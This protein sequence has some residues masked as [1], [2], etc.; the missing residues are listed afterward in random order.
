M[1]KEKI[2]KFREKVQGVKN[3]F[4]LLFGKERD[5]A[6]V[7]INSLYDFVMTELIINVFPIANMFKTIDFGD[8]GY[9][10]ILY[11]VGTHEVARLH[12][13]KG[14][15]CFLT[16]A[17]WDKRFDLNPIKKR[18]TLPMAKDIEEAK[19]FAVTELISIMEL[20]KAAEDCGRVINNV[21]KEN[22]DFK[23]RVN[24]LEEAMSHG[25]ECLE[26]MEKDKEIQENHKESTRWARV[27]LR[28]G[29]KVKLIN[30]LEVQ[31]YG[32]KIFNVISDPWSLGT[33]DN[34][35]AVKLEGISGGF[36]V[37]R[38]LLVRD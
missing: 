27:E 17:T 11:L 38:L 28:P 33:R 25:V 3:T 4:P 22:E 8:C 30:C 2:T 23:K 6:F 15:E 12:Y 19:G 16:M 14:K 31:T 1:D 36:C 21:F 37:D 7:A 10:D 34:N 18:I 20:T 24:Y 32:D 29:D 26:C 9:Y 35:K 13:I 5:D